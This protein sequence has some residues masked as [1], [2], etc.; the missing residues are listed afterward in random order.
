MPALPGL[1]HDVD[2]AIAFFSRVLRQPHVRQDQLAERWP[3]DGWLRP[4]HVSLDFRHP[5]R[6]PI[7]R[8]RVLV[9]QVVCRSCGESSRCTDAGDDLRV[10]ELG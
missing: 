2:L 7:V 8:D 4:R 3:W 10:R 1:F 6:E 5:A 9:V